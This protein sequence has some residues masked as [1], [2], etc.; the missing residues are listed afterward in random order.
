[1]NK[2]L[3]MRPENPNMPESCIAEFLDDSKNS[4]STPFALKAAEVSISAPAWT[5]RHRLASAG[6]ATG[7]LR[8]C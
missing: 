1:M 5:A 2:R 8:A 7:L 6:H 3:Q 4:A